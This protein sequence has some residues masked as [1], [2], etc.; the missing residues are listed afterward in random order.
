M[1]I[2]L[3]PSET[4]AAPAT[5]GPVEAESLS[6]PGLKSARDRALKALVR[7]SGQKNALTVLGVGASLQDEVARNLDLETAPAAPALEVYTGVLY[8]ALDP[9]GFTPEQAA[10]AQES[11]VVISAL[12]GAL[13][14]ADRIPAYRLSGGTALR[15]LGTAGTVKMSAFWKPHLARHLGPAAHDQL[16]IDCRSSAYAAAFQAPKDRTVTVKVVQLVDGARKVVSHNA[17]Q[18]RGLLSRHVIE[19][20]AAGES[21]ETARDLARVAGERWQVEL[22]EPAAGRAGELTVVLPEQ[23]AARG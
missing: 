2:L 9:A 22:T 8:D 13:R 3:P 7:V 23:E 21:V 11:V 10:V 12:W 17:K 1:L 6:W 15:G 4:K 5:G 14:P 19:R 16:I 20:V 18:T